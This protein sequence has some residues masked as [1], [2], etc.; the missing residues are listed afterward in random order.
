MISK[1]ISTVT[2]L[3]VIFFVSCSNSSDHDNAAGGGMG[4]AG[5]AGAPEGGQSKQRDLQRELLRLQLL[6]RT[7]VLLHGVMRVQVT[8]E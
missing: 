3:I 8:C 7:G 5:A 1:R 4:P 2:P 6:R